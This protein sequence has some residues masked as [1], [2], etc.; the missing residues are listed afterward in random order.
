[1]DGAGVDGAEG[2]GSLPPPPPLLGSGFV[3]LGAGSDPDGENEA[4]SALAAT[5][6]GLTAE[7]AAASFSPPPVALPMANAAP[8][9]I[10]TAATAMAAKRPGVIVRGTS[11][12]A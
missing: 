1:M 4:T 2:A 3:S 9:A 10:T 12:G 8:K 5:S 11:R 7:G 6:T